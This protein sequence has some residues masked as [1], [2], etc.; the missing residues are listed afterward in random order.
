MNEDDIFKEILALQEDRE[1]QLEDRPARRF[2]DNCQ[3]YLDIKFDCLTKND[4]DPPDFI[5]N[6]NSEIINLEVTTFTDK[7][8]FQKNAF[9]STLESIANPLF[10]KYKDLLPKGK[11]LL[12][13]F[14]SSKIDSG[15]SFGLELPDFK[16]KTNK[17]HLEKYLEKEIPIWLK[18]YKIDNQYYFPI[19]DN[20]GNQIG[21]INILKIADSNETIL[22]IFPQ[23]ISRFEKWGIEELKNKL[24]EIISQ[25]DNAYKDK[26]EL[27][28]KYKGPWWLLISDIDNLMNT[29]FL[30]FNISE[31]RLSSI[32]FQRVFLIHSK[33]TN[34]KIDELFLEPV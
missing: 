2:F 31:I 10:M 16:Y 26:K 18:E 6:R 9:F 1:Y 29:N 23:K 34:Y 17:K 27:F 3:K 32:V 19:L 4:N 14:P 8:I 11:Y 12:Y 7:Y 33:T 21:K 5:L 28:S 30:D 24:Q 15:K 20:K 13:Y 22:L 25:K